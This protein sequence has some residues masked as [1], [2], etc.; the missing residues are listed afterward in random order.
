MASR[1]APAPAPGTCSSRNHGGA[2]GARP[3]G[4]PAGRRRLSPPLAPSVARAAHPHRGSQDDAWLPSELS[5][6]CQCYDSPTCSVDIVSGISPSRPGCQ[7]DAN[8]RCSLCDLSVKAPVRDADWTAMIGALFRSSPHDS[9]IFALA[10]P[11]VLALA[12]DPLLSMVDTIFVGQ[13]G[14][15]ALAAL[16]VNSALFTLAFVVFNFLATATTPMVAAS[17]ATGD[18]ERAGKVTLQALG[19]A[20]VLGGVL[21]VVLVTCS[22]GALAL[23]GAGPETG[24]VHE[25]A[26][27]FLTIR[28]LAAPA[29]LLMTVGQGAFRGLQDMRTPLAI[30]LAANGIN[31]ALD[32]LLIVVLGWGVKGAATATT[33]A[34]WVAALA[35]LG[36]LYGR[37]DALGGLSPRLVLG[38]SMQA[39][40]A[41][42]TPFL[43]AGGAML[44]RTGLLLGTKT[45][46]SATAAR[47]GVVPVAAHQVVTQLWLLSSL[48]VDSVAI[49]GQSLV[50]VQL[51]RGDVAEAR[52]VSNRLLGIGLG[53]GA[54]LAAAFWLAEPIIPGIFSSDAEV[55]A[56]VRAVLP[57]AVAML[58]INAAVYVFDG[59][60]TGAADFKF[61]AGAMVVAAGTAVALLLGVEPLG[62]GLPGVWYAMGLLMLSRL[63]TMM[64]RYQSEDG[65]LPPSAELAAQQQQLMAAA[66]AAVLERSSGMASSSSSLGSLDGSS[67]SSIDGSD[68]PGT[69]GGFAA[70]TAS[71][72]L[73]GGSSS[74]VALNNAVAVDGPLL[75]P[76]QGSA[77]WRDGGR[78]T[79]SR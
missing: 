56:A 39:A 73:D 4:L 33:T 63:A 68:G 70:S 32:T 41:E 9:A 38:T 13:A 17:L 74:G 1:L 28:A 52:A 59:I 55:G 49:A 57:I 29:A 51:G 78:A 69:A 26:T 60:I 43:K 50:A 71:S 22:D 47:L 36:V 20:T 58:P 76:Q 2:R 8:T 79:R 37:R 16:G 66:S 77:A 15:D 46:A 75:E 25:L 27:E 42:M 34:E 45:L 5:G 40:V 3:R 6:Q 10:L 23:M 44:M 54:A 21:A 72:S 35:Y 53:A 11:A 48:V 62:L 65:P 30:T 24:N 61:M 67:S 12:A 18:K 19:L 64:W 7:H 31:L 14:T